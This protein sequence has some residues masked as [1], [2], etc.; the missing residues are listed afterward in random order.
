MPPMNTGLDT[1][2]RQSESLSGRRAGIP[3]SRQRQFSNDK[4]TE[5]SIF[6]MRVNGAPA[7]PSS[8]QLRHTT[9]P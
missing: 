3:F 5:P 1:L 6:F 8:S 7:E 9:L 4:S 2:A